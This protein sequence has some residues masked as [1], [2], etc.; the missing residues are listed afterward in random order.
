MGWV[1]WGG[2]RDGCGGQ[3]PAHPT[4]RIPECRVVERVPLDAEI[5]GR[6]LDDHDLGGAGRDAARRAHRNG[7]SRGLHGRL[8]VTTRM[9][10]QQR[11]PIPGIRESPHRHATLCRSGCDERR[12]SSG[13]RCFSKTHGRDAASQRRHA[14]G[15][16]RRRH[17]RLADVVQLDRPIRGVAQQHDP[18]SVWHEKRVYHP[19]MTCRRTSIDDACGWA[20]GLVFAEPEHVK[21][22]AR[23]ATR[24]DRPISRVDMP[25]RHQRHV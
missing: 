3:R 6:R 14:A 17:R 15:N 7:N 1:G 16:R 25:D 21:R 2:G 13:L 23:I 22:P 18:F 8:A 10:G 24:H 4:R 11:E 5:R 19:A 9:M 20:A 12:R